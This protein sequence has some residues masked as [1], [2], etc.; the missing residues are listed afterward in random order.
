MAVTTS[1]VTYAL[2]PAA[3]FENHVP[4]RTCIEHFRVT[5]LDRRLH[6]IEFYIYDI[7]VN[8]S[9]FFFHTLL[10]LKYQ[11]KNTQVFYHEPNFLGTSYLIKRLPC[12]ASALSFLLHMTKPSKRA[13]AM[14]LEDSFTMMFGLQP[15]LLQFEKIKRKML[16]SSNNNVLSTTAMTERKRKLS[17]YHFCKK[18]VRNCIPD[19]D[20]LFIVASALLR[21]CSDTV[22]RMRK[23]FNPS[24]SDLSANGKRKQLLKT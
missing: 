24:T 11:S 7:D 15:L 13:T 8:R 21:R 6:E 2:E 4:L 14:L 3:C 12:F 19:N 18:I 10:H 17:P 23:V 16:S 5:H 20:S 1:F 9:L 22:W